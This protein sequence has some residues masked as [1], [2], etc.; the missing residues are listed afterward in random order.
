[1]GVEAQYEKSFCLVLTFFSHI[2][3]HISSRTHSIPRTSSDTLTVW[4]ERGWAHSR[5][6][7]P[8]CCFS[9]PGLFTSDQNSQ[10]GTRDTAWVQPPCLFFQKTGNAVRAIGR[11]SSMAMISGLSGRKSSTGSPTSPINAEKL[12]SEG[13]ASPR[14]LWEGKSRGERSVLRS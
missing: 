8:C 9:G 14:H 12:E 11:L 1:M 2:N 3:S 10:T 4:G 7:A 13:K 5:G 6:P